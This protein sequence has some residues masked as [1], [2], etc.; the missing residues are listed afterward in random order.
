MSERTSTA[1]IKADRIFAIRICDVDDPLSLR[2]YRH[3]R[4]QVDRFH[5]ESR[6][7]AFRFQRP[8]ETNSAASSRLVDQ[9]DGMFQKLA[10]NGGQHK[11]EIK[12]DGYETAE[13]DVLITPDQTVTF[14]GE[15]KRIQ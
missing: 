14:A 6:F 13:F 11:V 7:R 10:L 8:L 4:P 3:D 12:A 2:P 5:F 1:H 15:L 9:F